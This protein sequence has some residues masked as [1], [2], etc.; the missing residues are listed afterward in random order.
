MR[1]KPVSAR[2][3]S[4]GGRDAYSS[5]HGRKPEQWTQPLLRHACVAACP[6]NAKGLPIYKRFAPLP[7][8][9]TNYQKVFASFF[10]KKCFLLF[11]FEKKNQKTFVYFDSKS[12]GRFGYFGSSL[13]FDRI[14]GFGI[15]AMTVL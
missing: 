2:L 5:P 15:D 9:A 11:F 8:H 12:T 7:G 1:D 14:G 3:R 4:A 13:D 6:T 10:K